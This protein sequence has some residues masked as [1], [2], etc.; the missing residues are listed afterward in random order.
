MRL[1]TC[2]LVLI[3]LLAAPTTA[4]VVQHHHESGPRIAHRRPPGPPDHAPAHGH[5]R[6]HPHHH[7]L[8]IVYD[9]SIGVYSV[10]GQAGVYWDG[11]RF[12]R[13]HED[14][15]WLSVSA[16]RGWL[17]VSIDRVPD[18]LAKRHAIYHGKKPKAHGRGKG[19]AK[20][21]H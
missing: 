15:W 10:S 5:R 21:A 12:L 20:H 11:R 7:D 6:R 2:H 1:R 16:D 13:W 8:T 19:A 3:A 14:A 18:R 4:C 17:R 9:D